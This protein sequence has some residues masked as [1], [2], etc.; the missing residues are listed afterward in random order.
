MEKLILE[1][2][3]KVAGESVGGFNARPSHIRTLD[4]VACRK[5]ISCMI[6]A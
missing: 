1:L 6:D 2:S 5:F 3:S 4:G